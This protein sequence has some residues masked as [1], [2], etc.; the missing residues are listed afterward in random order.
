MPADRCLAKNSLDVQQTNASD[1]QQVAQQLRTPPF[2]RRLVNAKQ[3]NRV[4][5][6]QAVSP[7]DQLQAQLALSQPRFTC[8]HHA[9]TQNIHEHAV[10][11]RTFSEVLGQISAQD[12]HNKGG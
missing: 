6:D 8:D 1:L 5:C 12:I 10:H 11:G 9:H 7:G 3:V 2:D 4:V